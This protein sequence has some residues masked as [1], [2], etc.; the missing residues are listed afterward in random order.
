MRLTLQCDYSRTKR[1]RPDCQRHPRPCQYGG[2][3]RPRLLS[4]RFWF[5]RRDRAS[6]WAALCFGTLTAV[7]LAGEVIPE[8]PST[9]LEEAGLRLLVVVLLLFPYLLFR[10]AAAFEPAS[11]RVE[12]LI[13]A[14]TVALSA[15][16]FALPNIPQEGEPHSTG[17][18]LY[19]GASSTG[20]RCRSSWRSSSGAPAATSPA[21][22]GDECVS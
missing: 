18:D 14:S 19:L 6:L 12:W 8:D 17:F 11:R 21:S 1:E 4:L 2:I 5:E 3:H 15:R 13:G 7:V 20:A 9:S 22:R 16:T 10:F